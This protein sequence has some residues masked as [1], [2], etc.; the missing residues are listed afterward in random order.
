MQLSKRSSTDGMLVSESENVP[1][2][3]R[4]LSAEISIDL[5]SGAVETTATHVNMEKST[6]EENEYN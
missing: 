1:R 5:T 3:A 4:V 2:P 6:V